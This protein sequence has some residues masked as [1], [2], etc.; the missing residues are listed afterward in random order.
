[1]IQDAVRLVTVGVGIAQGLERGK[2]GE[3]LGDLARGLVA[4]DGQL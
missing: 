4:K 1:V 2:I 3:R